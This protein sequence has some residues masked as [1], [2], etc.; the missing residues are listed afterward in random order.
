MALYLYTYIDKIDILNKVCDNIN[1]YVL[2]KLAVLVTREY[3][4]I[5]EHLALSVVRNF[6]PTDFAASIRTVDDITR[7]CKVA[8]RGT[9]RVVCR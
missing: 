4:T 3:Y 2:E 9:F 5:N 6:R 7:K 8:A 1:V